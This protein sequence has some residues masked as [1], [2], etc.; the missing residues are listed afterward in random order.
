MLTA[1]HISFGYRGNLPI[2]DDVSLALAPGQVLGLLAP[3]G[4]GKSTLMATMEC[5]L[6]RRSCRTTSAVG[7]RTSARKSTNGR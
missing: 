4:Y 5:P 1:E 6:R 7:P 3:S 2:L